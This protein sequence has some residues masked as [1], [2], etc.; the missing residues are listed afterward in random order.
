M[1]IL[2]RVNSAIQQPGYISMAASTEVG[3]SA[4]L[5]TLHKRVERMAVFMSHNQV[6]EWLY[7]VLKSKKKLYSDQITG[8]HNS[9]I[10]K[11]CIQR[12]VGSRVA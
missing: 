3:S 6:L 5:L 9:F 7:V 2:T 4:G 8:F 12:H 11:G 1:S 10:H